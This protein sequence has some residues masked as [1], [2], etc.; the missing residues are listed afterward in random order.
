MDAVLSP[1]P[2]MRT[3]C[4][5]I[6]RQMPTSPILNSLDCTAELCSAVLMASALSVVSREC[7][8]RFRSA[9]TQK[10]SYQGPPSFRG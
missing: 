9:F 1:S 7:R 4:E 8:K 6:S 5:W 2:Q 10:S 3:V